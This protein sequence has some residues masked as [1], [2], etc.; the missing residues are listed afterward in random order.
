MLTPRQNFI[1]TITPGGHPERFVNQYD[2]MAFAFYP[3]SMDQMPPEKGTRKVNPWGVTQ[4]YREDQPGAF[5]L[6][7]PDLLV[8]KDFENWKDYVKAPNI[9]YPE[10]AWEPWIAEAEKIDREQ[11]FACSFVAPGLFEQLHYLASMT[12]ALAAFYEYP[13]EVH[14]LIKFLTDWELK[15]ADGFISHLHPDMILHH[16][17]WGSRKST[18]LSPDMFAEF[19]LEP[20]KTIYGYYHENGVQY[21]VH[22]SDSYAATL[23]P[24]MIEMGINV[25]Q[26]CMTSNNIPELCEKYGDKIAFMGGLDGADIEKADWTKPWVKEQVHELCS[27]GHKSFIPC[28]TQGLPMSTYEGLYDCISECIA[29]E[30]EERK[31]EFE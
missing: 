27:H 30:S 7:T 31:A 24:Y 9:D 3:F 15:L 18:F 5:P 2:F 21:V 19:F 17:D 10:S 4:E 29:E 16:D 23:V 14:E 13:D 22:H 25:W 26:G 11:V 20:Y 8:I 6:D 28:I 12:E 1:E